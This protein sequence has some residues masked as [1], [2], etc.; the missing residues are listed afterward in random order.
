[1]SAALTHTAP[2]APAL[3]QRRSTPV[4]V[5]PAGAV[6]LQPTE[7]ALAHTGE[8]GGGPGGGTGGLGG[9]G[10]GTGGAGF[11]GGGSGEG[12]GGGAGGGGVMYGGG[13]M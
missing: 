2:C 3:L 13:N 4:T 1:V 9:D 5:V 8:G 10:G 6:V 7:R 12:G 11:G